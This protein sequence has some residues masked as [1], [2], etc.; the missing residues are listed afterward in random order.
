[1]RGNIEHTDGTFKSNG[2]QVD[3]HGHGGVQRGGAWTE[4]TK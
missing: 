3:S 4:G 1:M 2:V